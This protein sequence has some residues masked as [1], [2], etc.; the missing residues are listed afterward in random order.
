[1]GL[2]RLSAVHMLA[3]DGEYLTIDPEVYPLLSQYTW[4]LGR[5]GYYEARIHNRLWQL[6]RKVLNMFGV[7]VHPLKVTDHISRDKR[8]NLLSNLRVVGKMENAQNR[9]A[10]QSNTSGRK[11]VYWDT[12]RNKW[13][14]QIVIDKKVKALGRFDSF[15]DACAA[16]TEAE[17]QHGGVW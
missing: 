4:T 16:R 8:I 12:A 9:H 15:D 1:M 6:H 5:S 17:R 14:A 2:L 3:S 7:F 11:G 13:H 10:P